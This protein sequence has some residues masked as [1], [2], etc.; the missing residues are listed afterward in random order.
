MLLEIFW[1]PVGK[2]LSFH[3]VLDFL[4]P[5]NFYQILQQQA[6][7]STA[8]VDETLLEQILVLVWC[9]VESCGQYMDEQAVPGFDTI[10]TRLDSFIPSIF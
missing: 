2:D 4:L 1:L 6:Y 5:L 7:S 3:Y 10:A 9:L 8:A